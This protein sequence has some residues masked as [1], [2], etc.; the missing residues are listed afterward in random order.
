MG[1]DYFIPFTGDSAVSPSK[2]HVE[3]PFTLLSRAL[4]ELNR[5]GITPKAAGTK[6]MMRQLAVDGFDE[7]SHGYTNFRSFLRAAADR[8]KIVLD[9][10]S[11]QDYL[12]SLPSA[13]SPLG[14]TQ[15][16]SGTK[17]GGDAPNR[18]PQRRVRHDL[19]EAF[20]DWRKGLARV[21]DEATGRAYVFPIQASQGESSE[22][23]EK[24]RGWGAREDQY[25][26]I[27]PIS[28]DEQVSWMRSFAEGLNRPE[29]NDILRA[30]FRSDRPAA[31]FRSAIRAF[32]DID[33]DWREY[34]FDRVIERINNW[35][36]QENL[37]INLFDSPA[38]Q[39]PSRVQPPVAA[40][41][42]KAADA[43]APELRARLHAAID[44]M[45]AHELMQIR[46][47]VGYLYLG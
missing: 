35:A 39:S 10:E 27:T 22:I 4:T 13:L 47:P 16:T 1:A 6:V 2:S 37:E 41:A 29:V 26:E 15:S 5:R 24:R 46:L 11:D 33:E 7:R 28:F 32:P 14:S 38:T 31:I 34:L 36:Q 25:H 30:G 45:P 44:A 42:N 43:D 3:D 40:Q 20:I 19:W 18:L 8:G 12:V 9:T 23:A 21:Y 17:L